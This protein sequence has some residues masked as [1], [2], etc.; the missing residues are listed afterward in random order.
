MYCNHCFIVIWQR[1]KSALK[2]RGNILEYMNVLNNLLRNCMIWGKEYSFF[3]KNSPAAGIFLEISD[4]LARQ[5]ALFP[6]RNTA[7]FYMII[8]LSNV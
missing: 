7:I 3:S 2:T 4:R 6:G 8:R 1:A 5:S